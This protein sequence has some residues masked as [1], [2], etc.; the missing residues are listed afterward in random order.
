[1][2]DYQN[3]LDRVTNLV[4]N[5]KVEGAI[6]ILE[7]LIEKYPD[8]AGGHYKLAL[9][10]HSIGKNDK[11]LECF[12]TSVKLNPLDSSIYYNVG[13]IHFSNGNLKESESYFKKTIEVDPK[14]TDAVYALGKVYQK[15]AQE[16]F[17]EEFD[18]YRNNLLS[19]IETLHKEKEAEKAIDLSEKALKL[20]PQD[21]EFIN[22]HAV[23]CYNSE[24]I[25]KARKNINSA[26]ELSP[27]DPD[28]QDNYQEIVNWQ[29]QKDDEKTT[30]IEPERK[31]IAVFCGP[32]DKFIGHIIEHL[33]TQHKVKRFKNGS[34][35]DMQSL[36]K[37]SDLSWFE[38]CDGLI[39][40][41][42]KLPKE[43]H[44]ICRL[45]SYE[46]FTDVIKQVNWNNVDDLI[47]VAPHIRDIVLGQLP[48]IKDIVNIS[49]IKN[50]VDLQK[51]KFKDRQKGF[52]IA[53][54]GYINHK[55]N[56]SLLLQC[57]RSLIDIDNR[58]MLHIAGK[59]QELRFKL[60]F[61][62]I[63]EE[64][65]LTKNVIFHGWVDDING[66][67]EDKHFAVSTSV[68]ES[69]CH[70]IADPMACGIKPIIHNFVGAKELYPKKYIFNSVKDFTDMVL[71][72]D[73]KSSEYREYIEENYS[74]EK[75]ISEI[76][77]LVKSALYK[78]VFV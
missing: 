5:G 70:G 60:Y 50:G 40:H 65:E 12:E 10:Y 51:Y 8:F 48:T 19:A 28:I 23:I 26:I 47:F 11:A 44:T 55:K 49:V 58:Y 54:I 71:S 20:F 61:D 77:M 18:N 45:H 31:K 74:Q 36:M 41:A 7:G 64:M 27:N 63:I 59:H 2:T 69:F 16:G 39:I 4:E 9:L 3:Y 33:S 1:M 22:N 21:A 43:C 6:E 73:Y 66:W 30:I 13:V 17:T 76:D 72:D 57:M 68:L 24:M 46:A 53:Y 67:L 29:D 14:N 37:W 62:H 56:P 25:D 32:D 75:Q 42:A 38:W 52:N 78:E 15:L 35:Q 34:I